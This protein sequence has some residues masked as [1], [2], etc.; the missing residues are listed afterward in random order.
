MTLFIDVHPAHTNLQLPGFCA[1]QLLTVFIGTI[2][3]FIGSLTN[4]I[5]A[6][7]KEEDSR[8]DTADAKTLL[9]P[10]AARDVQGWRRMM[11]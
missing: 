1:K 3:L 10:R 8:F 2:D 4:D 6:Q 5:I 9:I 7:T 11:K